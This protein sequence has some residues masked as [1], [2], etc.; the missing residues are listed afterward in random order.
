VRAALAC[1]LVACLPVL[2]ACG[3]AESSAE[4]FEGQEKAVAEAVEDIQDAS[5]S[6]D[7]EQLCR[8]LLARSYVRRIAQGG[9]CE[10]ELADA[11][12]DADDSELD[13]VD[14]TVSGTSARAVVRGARTNDDRRAVMS[15][16]REGGRWRA[17]A[18]ASGQR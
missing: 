14:V 1:L 11:L 13:V 4:D 16:V 18:I 17:N 5:A 2:S 8:D 12:D 10:D 15:F 7:A 3:A 6:S 9:R